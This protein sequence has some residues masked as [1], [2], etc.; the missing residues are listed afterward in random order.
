[1]LSIILR[2]FILIEYFHS[3]IP[4]TES[5]K[6]PDVAEI[7]CSSASVFLVKTSSASDSTGYSK[8]QTEIFLILN[9]C[10]VV[11]KSS[12]VEI[13]KYIFRK[14]FQKMNEYYLSCGFSTFPNIKIK[15]LNTICSVHIQTSVWSTIKINQV[16]LLS[17][18]T[19]WA[20]ER[21][22]SGLRIIPLSWQL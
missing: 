6:T 12:F 2:I 16:T 17:F 13:P 14:G 22:A 20:V 5:P 18:I 9:W 19:S 8:S 1:M 10:P 21:S 3:G 15:Y 11:A 4:T 7:F